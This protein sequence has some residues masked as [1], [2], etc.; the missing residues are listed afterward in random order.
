VN[1]A[2]HRRDD[3]GYTLVEVMVATGILVVVLA[4]LAPLLT[5]TLSGFGRQTDRSGALDQAGIVLQQIEH[6]VLGASVL[7]VASPGN[8]LQLIV[9]AVGSTSC[10]EYRVA[11]LASPQPLTLQRRVRTVASGAWP[12]GGGWQTLMS[13]LQ[14]SGQ[15]AGA[16]IPN[17]AGANPFAATA[18]GKSVAVDLRVQNGTSAVVELTTTATGRTTTATTAAAAAA[19]WTAQCS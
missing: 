6:D 18:S 11:S 8:D 14:L 17:P 19:S 2:Q 1:P 13:I 10:V 3:R 15:S 12:S 5:G 7:N 9:G 4:I 16:V